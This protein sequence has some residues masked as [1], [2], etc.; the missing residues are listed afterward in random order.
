MALMSQNYWIFFIMA[1]LELYL[2]YE[3]CIKAL[4]EQLIRKDSKWIK[5]FVINMITRFYIQLIYVYLTTS[6]KF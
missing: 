2:S 6:N 3:Q 1:D 5:T 4:V